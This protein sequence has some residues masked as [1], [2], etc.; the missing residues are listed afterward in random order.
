[1]RNEPDPKAAYL[2]ALRA[3]RA[4]AKRATEAAGN[5][6]MDEFTRDLLDACGLALDAAELAIPAGERVAFL[7]EHG[8]PDEVTE[9]AEPA[10]EGRLTVSN[11]VKMA[12]AVLLGAGEWNEFWND[13]DT[14]RIVVWID[15]R[16]YSHGT[17]GGN[18]GSWSLNQTELKVSV[19]EN[20]D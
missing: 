18:Y 19:D 9:D 5:G 15:G 8:V 16:W 3:Y 10:R 13:D 12:A 11:A 17:F 2:T 14:E 20:A 7:R 6:Q 1:M 4:A